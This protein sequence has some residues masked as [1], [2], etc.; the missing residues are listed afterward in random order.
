MTELIFNKIRP[1]T[2]QRLIQIVAES[3]RRDSIEGLILGG[4]ELP[5]I[6]SQADFSDMQ[7]FDT[8][9]I[10]VESIVTKMF[11]P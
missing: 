7:I 1:E 9:K 4:T 3:K 5:L 8:M 2:K 11:E 6:L 10:H